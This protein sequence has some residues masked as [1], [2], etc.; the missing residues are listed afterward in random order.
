MEAVPVRKRD[1]SKSYAGQPGG[2][3]IDAIGTSKD[4]Q[5]YVVADT[6]MSKYYADWYDRYPI[7]R[8]KKHPKRR[9]DQAVWLPINELQ[10]LC[11]WLS[12]FGDRWIGEIWWSFILLT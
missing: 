1:P 12:E 3:Q 7:F 2:V 9:L 4:C 6:Y 11:L 8:A 5:A 10:D